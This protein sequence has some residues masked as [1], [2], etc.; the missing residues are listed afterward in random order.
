MLNIRNA[1]ALLIYI[2][3]LLITDKET[4]KIT[5]LVALQIMPRYQIKLLNR[6]FH[7]QYR[8]R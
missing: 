6:I 4:L 7:G 8:Q 1:I 5:I 3:C 2:Y